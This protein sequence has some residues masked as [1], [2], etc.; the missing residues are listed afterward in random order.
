MKKIASFSFVLLAAL[1]LMVPAVAG[2]METVTLEGE[3][4]CGKCSLKEA[5]FAK[6]QNV[7]AV[8]KDGEKMYYYVVKNA[9]GSEYGD[10]CMKSR[11]VKVTGTVEEKEGRMWIA[12]SEIVTVEKEG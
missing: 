1:M 12:A 11:M 9:T 4:V 10:V 6:C 7:V 3:M 2:D 5:D 8:D